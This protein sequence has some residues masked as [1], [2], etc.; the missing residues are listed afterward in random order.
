MGCFLYVCQ[1]LYRRKRQ[2]QA[3]MRLLPRPS[4]RLVISA[5]SNG[6]HDAL[7]LGILGTPGAVLLLLPRTL[8]V[9]IVCLRLALMQSHALHAYLLR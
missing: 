9:N 5:P 2:C 8:C 4:Y 6:V 7:C 1:L 3:H